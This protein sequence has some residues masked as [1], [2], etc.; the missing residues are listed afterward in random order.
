MSPPFVKFEVLSKQLP[1]FDVTD[2]DQDVLLV[3]VTN[4][5][6]RFGHRH[7]DCF[8]MRTQNIK[9]AAVPAAAAAIKAKRF[10]FR[11]PS[12]RRLRRPV[13]KASKMRRVSSRQRLVS[14]DAFDASSKASSSIETLYDILLGYNVVALQY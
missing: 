7:K 5:V 4:F 2:I 9:A 14:W 1:K 8:T 6:F 11:C 13:R 3:R 10:A 12:S